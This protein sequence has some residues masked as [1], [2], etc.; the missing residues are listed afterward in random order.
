ML[1]EKLAIKIRQEL[2]ET[3]ISEVME[4]VE[5]LLDE[6]I[7]IKDML[8]RLPQSYSDE[9]YEIKCSEIYQYIYDSYAG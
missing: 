9:M 2:P 7:V 3:D 8:D 6:S 5:E 1:L 4:E